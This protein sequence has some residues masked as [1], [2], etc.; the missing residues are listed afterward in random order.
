MTEPM[1]SQ[2]DR[3]NLLKSIGFTLAGASVAGCA[4][5]A[6]AMPTPEGRPALTAAD[7]HGKKLRVIEPGMFVTQEFDAERVT[8]ELGEDRR[9]QAVRIG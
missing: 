9:I 6:G 5:V 1:P 3:R 4:G 2:K 7:M 8:I